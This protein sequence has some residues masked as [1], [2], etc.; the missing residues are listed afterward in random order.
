MIMAV[1]TKPGIASFLRMSYARY[2]AIGL[3]GMLVVGGLTFLISL[4]AEDDIV[5]FILPC[6]VQHHTKT[7]S[8]YR[9]LL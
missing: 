9:A 5:V 4:T 7:Y 6:F 2:G 3:V 1:R 8:S